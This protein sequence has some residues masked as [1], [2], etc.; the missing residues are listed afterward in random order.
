MS[1]QFD[2]WMARMKYVILAVIKDL[3]TQG[4]TMSITV[5]GITSQRPLNLTIK[6][7]VQACIQT[8]N[9]TT[10]NHEPC[11]TIKLR[12]S[13]WEVSIFFFSLFFFL[14]F[15]FLSFFLLGVLDEN[16]ILG[17]WKP[18]IEYMIPISGATLVQGSGG[19]EW[20]GC[21]LTKRHVCMMQQ[22]ELSFENHV[23]LYMRLTFQW[24]FIYVLNN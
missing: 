10:D 2:Q 4:I 5:S 6:W 19:Q 17:M 23:H 1:V 9:H 18:L 8:P 24:S 7:L 12:I 11:R 16:L 21:P 3:S 22:S 15:F 14:F 13:G 20:V